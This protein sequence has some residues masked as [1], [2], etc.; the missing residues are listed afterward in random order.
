MKCLAIPVSKISVVF[1]NAQEG[2]GRYYG[3]D[4]DA[5]PCH[6][7]KALDSGDHGLSVRCLLSVK[8]FA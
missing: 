5:C 8:L 6:V 4:V 3:E 7:S 1:L 2:H